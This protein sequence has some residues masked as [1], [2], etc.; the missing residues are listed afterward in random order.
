M[1][2]LYDW[3]LRLAIAVFG[4]AAYHGLPVRMTDDFTRRAMP[5]IHEGTSAAWNVGDANPRRSWRGDE[6]R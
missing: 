4:G 6:V 2:K 5:D 3:F 1:S